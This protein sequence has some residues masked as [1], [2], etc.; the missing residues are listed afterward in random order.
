MGIEE[1]VLKG[2]FYLAK[3]AHTLLLVFQFFNLI[4]QFFLVSKQTCNDN[5][6]VQTV[7]GVN[8]LGK[9]LSLLHRRL[10]DLFEP[11][12]RL[13]DIHIIVL[14]RILFEANLECRKFE[15]QLF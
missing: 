5:V 9:I 4:S 15:E 11:L 6:F 12:Q 14:D 8:Y 3:D 2:N 7:L 10:N 13:M 1:L